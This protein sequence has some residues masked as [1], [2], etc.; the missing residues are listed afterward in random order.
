MT[1]VRSILVGLAAAAALVVAP[2]VATADAA[3]ATTMT[4]DNHPWG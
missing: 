4:L 1:V 3:P 2:A